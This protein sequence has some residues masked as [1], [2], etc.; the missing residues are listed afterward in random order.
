MSKE[1]PLT[2]RLKGA[3]KP[4]RE[5]FLLALGV[6]L[7]MKLPKQAEEVHFIRMSIDVLEHILKKE[8]KKRR[9]Q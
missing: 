5:V 3:F 7:K 9:K 8:I 2:R 6:F 1:K 4:K